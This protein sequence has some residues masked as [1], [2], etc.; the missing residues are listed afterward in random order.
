MMH[1]TFLE[2]ANRTPAAVDEV[3][4]DFTVSFCENADIF[5]LT[6]EVELPD[7]SR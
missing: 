6:V 5:P 1:G 2:L 7:G 3:I 4:A